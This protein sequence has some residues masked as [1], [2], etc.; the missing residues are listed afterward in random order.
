[1]K[2]E[3]ISWEYFKEDTPINI[4]KV[5]NIKVKQYENKRV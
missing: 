1:M 2:E 4:T 5:N 3:Y